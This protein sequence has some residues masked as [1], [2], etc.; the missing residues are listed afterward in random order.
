[1]RQKLS[2]ENLDVYRLARQFAVDLYRETSKFPPEERFGLT[3]RIRRAA[4][5]IPVNIAEGASRRSKREF[6]RFLLMARG[7]SADLRVLL[8]VAH[9]T[10]ILSDETYS[11]YEQIV[12]R[13]SSIASG[14]IRHA[15][16][17]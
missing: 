8:D 15:D 9:E 12:D 5:S 3:S 10:G 13:I 17:R 11:D 2:H 1:M 16:S 6:S 4:V 7:S 14:L